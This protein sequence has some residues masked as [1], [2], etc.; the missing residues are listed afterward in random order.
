MLCNLNNIQQILSLFFL[1]KVLVSKTGSQVVE[2]TIIKSNLLYL[3]DK[4]EYNINLY[5][6]L[7][8]MP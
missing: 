2:S 1:M 5:C 8:V 7:N 3:N 4:D 6:I